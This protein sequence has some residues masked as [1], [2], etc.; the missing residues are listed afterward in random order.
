MPSGSL[1]QDF[2][3]GAYTLVTSNTY[4][5]APV[6]SGSL[7]VFKVGAHISQLIVTYSSFFTRYRTSG[8]WGQW[9]DRS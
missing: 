9:H 7:L 6:G 4:I 2:P 5:D 3:M 8:S 1:T